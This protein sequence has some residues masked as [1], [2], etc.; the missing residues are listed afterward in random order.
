V[1]HAAAA[2]PRQPLLPG[3]RTRHWDPGA[4]RRSTAQRQGRRG[5]T[6]ESDRNR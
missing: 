2:Q 5:P 3:L 6:I 1:G 4:S